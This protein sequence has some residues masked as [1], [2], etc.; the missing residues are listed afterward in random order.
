MMTVGKSIRFKSFRKITLRS[1]KT[2]KY[3]TSTF[4]HLESA[5][6][7]VTVTDMR[8]HLRRWENQEK[9]QNR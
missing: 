6:S 5:Q 2:M 1:S 8:A 4:N 7:A 3:A 9:Q